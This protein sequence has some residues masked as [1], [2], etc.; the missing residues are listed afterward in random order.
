M[1]KFTINIFIFFSIGFGLLSFIAHT[2]V[3]TDN[4]F[5]NKQSWI[6]V[7]QRI[8]KSKGR[9]VETTLYLGDSVGGQFYPFGEK[10]NYL[11][12]NGSVLA[13]GTYILAYNAIKHNPQINTIVIVSVPNVIGH[14]FER[15]RTYNK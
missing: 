7:Y 14:K 8:A 4:Y 5:S 15:S 1:K 11:T 13:I 10:D 3:S 6:K 9:I 2:L 12:S